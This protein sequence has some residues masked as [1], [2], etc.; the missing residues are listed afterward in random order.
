M[1]IKV[2]KK[3]L[4]HQ[5]KVF[6][7]YA[8]NVTLPNGY[9]TTLSIIRH[10][11]ASAMVAITDTRQIL[12]IRQ[13][14]HAAD[15]YIWEIPAGTLDPGESPMDCAQ[16]E[17]VEETGFSADTWQKLGEIIP[18]PGYSDERIHIYLAENLKQARQ[19]LDGDEV[20]EVHPFEFTE[21]IE[22]IRTGQIMDAKSITGIFMAKCHLNL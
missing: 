11:G 3:E 12:L 16:R 21:V 8:E 13:Y 17:L 15:G 18:V 10:P 4:I 5:G 20:L 1:E 2:H 22:M 19:N 14:R 6:K 9:N 7:L